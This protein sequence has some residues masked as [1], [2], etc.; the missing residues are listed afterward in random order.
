MFVSDAEVEAIAAEMGVDVQRTVGEIER[1]GELAS[2]QV[3]PSSKEEVATEDSE[4]TKEDSSQSLGTN[5]GGK[6][7]KRKKNK[8][9][10]E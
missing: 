2:D 10:V 6:K 3:K 4:K 7:A 9:G 8:G 1:D 5:K